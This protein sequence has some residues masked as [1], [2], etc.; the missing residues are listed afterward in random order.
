M[1]VTFKIR[2]Q[3]PEQPGKQKPY[4]QEF[5]LSD[6]D[7]ADRVLEMLQNLEGVDDVADLMAILGNVAVGRA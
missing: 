6:V 2:R 5:V 3:N 7:P 1:D 4:W